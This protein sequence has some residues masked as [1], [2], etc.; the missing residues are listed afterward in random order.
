MSMTN[1]LTEVRAHPDHP[2]DPVSAE[3]VVHV[4]EV[5]GA[6]AQQPTHTEQAVR[7]VG[8]R[9]LRPGEFHIG[10]VNV[11]TDGTTV[12]TTDDYP[13]TLQLPAPRVKF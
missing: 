7:F 10:V 2:G 11:I 12:G 9:A 6:E 3:V 4:D 8:G 1:I 13:Q 5:L